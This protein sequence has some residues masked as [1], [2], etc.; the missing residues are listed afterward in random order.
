[1]KARHLHNE[2]RDTPRYDVANSRKV[3]CASSLPSALSGRDTPHA[4]AVALDDV[5]GSGPH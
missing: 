2:R 5:F 4:E 3:I 1:V